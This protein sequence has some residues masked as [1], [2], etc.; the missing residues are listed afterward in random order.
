MPWCGYWGTGAAYWWILP[1]FGL[2]LMG[3]MFFACFRG[4]GCLRGRGPRARSDLEREVAGLKEE[5]RKL[6]GRPG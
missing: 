6:G 1:L 5:L 4:A 2:V 3:V